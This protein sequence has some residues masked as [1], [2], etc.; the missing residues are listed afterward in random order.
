MILKSEYNEK[1]GRTS[2]IYLEAFPYKITDLDLSII[3]DSGYEYSR[4]WIESIKWVP[5]NPRDQVLSYFAD[6]GTLWIT[7]ICH[8]EYILTKDIL[9]V[10]V[11]IAL[12]KYEKYMVNYKQEI[13]SPCINENICDE[14][15]QLSLY[16]D[17]KY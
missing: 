3:L 1:Y 17:I 9:M 7:D 8:I 4:H 2:K 5:R 6:G 16:G 14:I 10:G 13:N 12:Q 15:I 11:G